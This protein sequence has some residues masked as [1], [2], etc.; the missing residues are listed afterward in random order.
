MK[1]NINEDKTEYTEVGRRDTMKLY[2]NYILLLLMSTTENSKKTKQFK[3]LRSI[4]SEKNEI[5]KETG[6]QIQ[7]RYKCLYDVVK[8]LITIFF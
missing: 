3:W 1:T 7:P 4:L 6:A 8:F 2:P 5:E